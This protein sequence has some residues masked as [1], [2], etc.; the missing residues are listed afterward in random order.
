MFVHNNNTLL[1][2]H[3][4]STR[5]K[6][7]VQLEVDQLLRASELMDLEEEPSTNTLL[8]SIINNYILNTSPYTHI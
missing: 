5:G 6:L 7:C 3:T 8:I 1:E 4:F 2:L